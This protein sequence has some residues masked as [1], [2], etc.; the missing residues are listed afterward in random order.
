MIYVEFRD[1]RGRNAMSDMRQTSAGMEGERGSVFFQTT[2]A[3]RIRE[4][5]ASHNLSISKSF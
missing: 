1:S 4:F 5:T 2:S 3:D